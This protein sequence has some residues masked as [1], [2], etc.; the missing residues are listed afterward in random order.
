[1]SWGY[2]VVQTP[3]TVEK[4]S[5]SVHGCVVAATLKLTNK[6]GKQSGKEMIYLYNAVLKI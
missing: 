3:G 1:M 4:T 6:E 5:Q 2:K